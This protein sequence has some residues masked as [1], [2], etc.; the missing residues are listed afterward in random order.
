MKPVKREAA[1]ATPQPQRLAILAVNGH[2]LLEA[3]G[4]P[5]WVEV[6]AVR[7]DPNDIGTVEL[8]LKGEQFRD[9]PPGAPTPRVNAVFHSEQGF[10]RFEYLTYRVTQ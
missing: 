4:F 5:E 9:V 7:A 8:L 2:L 3:L 10:Q 6:E 1:S